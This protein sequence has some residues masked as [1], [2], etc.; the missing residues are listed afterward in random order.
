M[1]RP[2]GADAQA[3]QARI[4]D[5]ALHLFARNG[6][7]GTSIRDVARGA[8]VSLAMVHHYFQSKEGLYEACI[9]SMLKE[10]S[11]LRVRLTELLGAGTTSPAET[12]ERAVRI[13]FRFAREHRVAVLLLYRSI[14]EA[15]RLDVSVHQDNVQ[16]FLKTAS[17]LLGAVTGR[18]AESFRLPLQSGVFV[19][20]RYAVSADEDLGLFARGQKDLPNAAALVEDH[21][22]AATLAILGFQPVEGAK[23]RMESSPEVQAALGKLP[24]A[25]V[26]AAKKR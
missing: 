4:I 15:G 19:I 26:K 14:L 9:Q 23:A 25:K 10:L 17:E 6:F 11:Q 2:V 20:G 22:V 1:A 3:T 18:P 21:L 8:K 24:S 7:G 5:S 13:G 12:L 16:P